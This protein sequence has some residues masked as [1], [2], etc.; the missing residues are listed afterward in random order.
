M[1][2]KLR[3]GTLTAIMGPSGAGKTTFLMTLLDKAAFGQCTGEILI[4]GYKRNLKT[5]RPVMGFV[6]QVRDCLPFF[7]RKCLEICMRSIR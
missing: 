3:S 7:L 5:M 1:T 6:P 2:G 4:N